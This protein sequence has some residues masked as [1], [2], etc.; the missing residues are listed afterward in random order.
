[1]ESYRPER[2]YWSVFSFVLVLPLLLVVVGFYHGNYVIHKYR[3][4]ELEPTGVVVKATNSKP[5]PT[6]NMTRCHV[7]MG[8][9]LS[10]TKDC[11]PAIGD[12]FS[13][14]SRVFPMVNVS[15]VIFNRVPK[16]G[17]STVNTVT[18]SLAERNRY[19]RIHSRIYDHHEIKSNEQVCL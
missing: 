11:N 19:T 18:R 16:C 8:A 13:G 7:F 12:E 15:M 14:T 6:Q 5:Q 3:R 9:T 4:A 17:S 1:M 2:P 10:N